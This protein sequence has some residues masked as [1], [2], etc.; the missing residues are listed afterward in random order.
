MQPLQANL[1]GHLGWCPARDFAFARQT[2]VVPLAAAE[3]AR[4]AQGLPV[5]FQKRGGQWQAVALMGS[6][7]GRNLFVSRDGKW[8]AR[9]VPAVLRVYPF[10]LTE[11]GTLGLWEDYEPDPL[12]APGA[13]PFYDGAGLSD[14]LQQTLR[15]LKTVQA[16]IAAVNRTLQQLDTVGALTAWAVPLGDAPHPEGMVA[17]LSALDPKRFETLEDAL[18]LELFRSGAMR[19]LHAHLDSLHHAESFTALTKAALAPEIPA[20][21]QMNKREQAADFLA[22]LAEDLGDANL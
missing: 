1:H 11:D 9:F 19:W 3:I 8:R 13:Q 22:A 21:R 12:A 10:L 5:L 15:F 4:V 18:L 6:V 7:Q 16:G 20:P 14:R 17:G 2:T